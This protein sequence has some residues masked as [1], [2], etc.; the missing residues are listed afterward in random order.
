[1]IN[2]VIDFNKY[3]KPDNVNPH[4]IIDEMVINL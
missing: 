1:M 3:R 4:S 2:N